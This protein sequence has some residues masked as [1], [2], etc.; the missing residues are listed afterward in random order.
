MASPLSLKIVLLGRT[1]VGKSSIGLRF[2]EGKFVTELE[3]TLGA[4]YLSKTMVVEGKRVRFNIWDTAGQE[5]YRAMAKMYYQDAQAAILVY[6]VTS[7][8]SFSELKHWHKELLDNG[9]R[10]ISNPY[11]VIAVAGNKLDLVDQEQVS[12]TEARKWTD[13]IHASLHQTSTR[14]GTGIEGLFLA[15]LPSSGEE[16]RSEQSNV[17]LNQQQRT[18]KGGCAC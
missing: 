4:A 13:S 1:G 14:A 12:I 16:T 2:T 3:S 10:D 9:P 18:Q 15:L 7:K 17:R 11:P 6:D 8:D 5:R